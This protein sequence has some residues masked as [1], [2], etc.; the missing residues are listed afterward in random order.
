MLISHACYRRLVSCCAS[1]IILLLYVTACVAQTMP[2]APQSEP[3]YIQADQAH[4]QHNMNTTLFNGHVSVTQ[5]Q[6]H[7]QADRLMV[8]TNAS[9][10]LQ[11][12][13]ASSRLP[14]THYWALTTHHTLVHLY[15]QMMTFYPKTATLILVNNARAT[16]NNIRLSSQTMLY[17][18]T[19]G[20]ITIPPWHHNRA[21]LL[22]YPPQQPPTS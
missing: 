3:I 6:A 13:I 5:G 15:A 20:T 2:L 22:Y 10:T 12:M 18:Q 16:Q 21:I 1:S 14:T 19:S 4:H 11:K 17:H 7:L 9:N 8:Y